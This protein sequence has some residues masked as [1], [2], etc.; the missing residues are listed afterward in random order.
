MSVVFQR[1][2]F[3]ASLVRY[4][5][6]VSLMFCNPMY[7]AQLG[8]VCDRKSAEE[9]AEMTCDLLSEESLLVVV[10]RMVEE[11]I[12]NTADD[13]LGSVLRGNNSL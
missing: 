9:F 4:R 7:V 11:E 1:S 3:M 8:I 6:L 13:A 12:A 5:E 2:H 10:S